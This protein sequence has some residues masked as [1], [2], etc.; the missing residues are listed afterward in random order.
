MVFTLEELA[1]QRFAQTPYAD[2]CT[3]QDV[4][5]NLLHQI[6]QHRHVFMEDAIAYYSIRIAKKILV[7]DILS[8]V[9]SNPFLEWQVENLDDQIYIGHHLQKL[10]VSF[11]YHCETRSNSTFV[12]R[13]TVQQPITVHDLLDMLTDISGVELS[14]PDI[15]GIKT[16]AQL[17]KAYFGN[18]VEWFYDSTGPVNEIGEALIMLEH[19]QIK[20]ATDERKCVFLSRGKL[21]FNKKI[22]RHRFSSV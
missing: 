19:M 5:P 14:L 9:N 18:I 10:D 11:C 3:T 16:H 8:R 15:I 2:M 13:H 21:N 1:L 12:F 17:Q 4:P 6:R 20:N 22:V 7:K